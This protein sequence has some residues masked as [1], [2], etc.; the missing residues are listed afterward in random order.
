M[1]DTPHTH[2]PRLV[3][4]LFP[5]QPAT[6]PHWLTLGGNLLARMRPLIH[7]LSLGPERRD[8]TS[9]IA[10]RLLAFIAPAILLA[11]GTATFLFLA[12]AIATAFGIQRMAPAAAGAMAGTWTFLGTLAYGLLRAGWRLARIRWH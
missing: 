10:T 7:V 1:A 12:A 8:R 2:A 6:R 5:D 9:G 11:A 3:I 4:P